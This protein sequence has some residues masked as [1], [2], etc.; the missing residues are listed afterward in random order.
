[1]GYKVLITEKVDDVGPGL[2]KEQGY[3]LVYGTGP[4]EET[5]IRECAD[6]DGA[7]T[8]N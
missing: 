6:C 2:L 5:L 1:M 4:D 3:E 8:R 7:L